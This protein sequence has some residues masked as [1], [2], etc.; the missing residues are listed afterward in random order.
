MRAMK[1]LSTAVV[2]LTLAA[3][4]AAETGAPATPAKDLTDLPI[5]KLMD[6]EVTSVSRTPQKLS[7]SPAAVYVITQEDIQR[8]G[9]TTIAEA[10]RMAPGL[11]VARIDASRWA[12]SARGFNDFFANKLLVLNDGRSVYTPLFSGVFWDVQDTLLEDIERIE[13]IRGPGATL[14]G[15]NAVNGVIN[16]ISKSAD[17]T[18]GGLVSAGGGN[19]ERGFGSARYGAKAGEKGYYRAYVKYFDRDN[20][21]SPQGGAATDGWDVFRTGFRNDWFMS[22]Q[23]TLTFQGDYY[24][25]RAKQQVYAFAPPTFFQAL[26]GDGDMAGGNLIGTWKYKF[27]E[28]NDLA[29]KLYYDRTEREDRIHRERR[30]TYDADFQHRF[31]LGE[32]QSVLWGV[33]FRNTENDLAEGRDNTGFVTFV[34]PSRSDNLYS[35]FVQDEITLVEDRLKFTL[36]T[37]VEHN[38]YSGFEFQ[39]GA[40][41]LW[42]PHEKHSV[43]AAASRAVRS[44][45]QFEDDI[46][47][48]LAPPPIAVRGNQDFDSEKLVAYEL[49]YRVQ[50]FRT[51]SLDITGFYNVYDDLRT[52][53]PAGTVVMPPAPFPVP[54]FTPQN[55]MDGETCGAEAAVTWQVTTTWKLQGGYT[56]LNMM[57][58]RDAASMGIDPETEEA[59]SP[60]QQFHVRSYLDLPHNLQLDSAVYYV[61]GLTG[62]GVPAHLRWDARLG[63]KATKN[64][65]VSLN[66]QNILD[67]KHPEFGPGFLVSPSEIERSIFGKITWR[68]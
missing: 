49:G 53:E 62:R 10:L 52:I 15:A 57:L 51:V 43:W 36:G 47:L 68:F 6:L 32:R 14:W 9:A 23:S 33:G 16:I 26:A 19:E 61:S 22:E 37:K 39:P 3:A 2:S 40:R 64:V 31:A 65:E 54:L 21:A 30:N 58:H 56:W 28:D 7:Q 25:G 17:Q 13:V 55:M 29:L 4:Q 46:R 67:D 41:W 5:E 24:T 63:W 35:S 34:P 48:W 50:P 59:S 8:S 20:F 12:I 1:A 11:D 44:P 18:L 38:D 42:T 66:I 45:S 27:S 60:R